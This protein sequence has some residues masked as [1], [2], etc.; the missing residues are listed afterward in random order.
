MVLMSFSKGKGSGFRSG[1]L[2]YMTFELFEAM[3]LCGLYEFASPTP[4]PKTSMTFNIAAAGAV[5]GEFL[6]I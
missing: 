3:C 4:A 2:V 5:D 6:C 1:Y